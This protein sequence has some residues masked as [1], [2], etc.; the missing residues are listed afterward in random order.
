MT[1]DRTS[2]DVEV[3]VV[4]QRD[5]PREVQ[6]GHARAGQ[7]RIPDLGM[8]M[9][10][11]PTSCSHAAGASSLGSAPTGVLIAAQDAAIRCTWA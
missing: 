2:I 10:T 8:L 3:L 7:Q 5:R 4:V 6:H 9:A 1:D 11:I